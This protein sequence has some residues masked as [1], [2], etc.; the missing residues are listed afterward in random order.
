MDL[1]TDPVNEEEI[2]LMKTGFPYMFKDSRIAIYLSSDVPI[3][4]YEFPFFTGENL[5]SFA[6]IYC[7]PN[8]M[9]DNGSITVCNPQMNRKA[10]R[11][12]DSKDKLF[13]SYNYIKRKIASNPKFTL[14][15]EG[16]FN[17]PNRS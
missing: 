2:E 13:K 7:L 1:G 3:A 4:T 17:D 8:C 16:S 6:F 14:I 11:G 12:F 5:E 15:W 9:D 10:S